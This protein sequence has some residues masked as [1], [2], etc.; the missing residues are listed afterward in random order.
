MAWHPRF[1]AGLRGEHHHVEVDDMA[2][3]IAPLCRG[4]AVASTGLALGRYSHGGLRLKEAERGRAPM[5]AAM[6]S[7]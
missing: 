4:E 7:G 1:L 5:A 2:M 3:V 6:G